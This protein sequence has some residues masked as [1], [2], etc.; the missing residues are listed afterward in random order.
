MYQRATDSREARATAGACAAT[1]DSGDTDK[2]QLALGKEKTVAKL[3][4]QVTTAYTRGTPPSIAS[5]DRVSSTVFVSQFF[6]A[7]YPRSDSHISRSHSSDEYV[8]RHGQ[9]EE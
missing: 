3:A 8:G 6:R 4:R 2:S 5:K 9:D 7:M 1:Y